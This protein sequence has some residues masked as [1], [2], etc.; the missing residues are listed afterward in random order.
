MDGMHQS[1]RSLLVHIVIAQLKDLSAFVQGPT[2][3][4][5]DVLPTAAATMPPPEP[6]G[7]PGLP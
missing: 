1:M 6:R 5:R 2:P 7:E 3:K 4:R